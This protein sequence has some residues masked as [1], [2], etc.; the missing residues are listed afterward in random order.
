MA[1]KAILNNQTILIGSWD[2]LVLTADISFDNFKYGH[3]RI[4]DESIAKGIV[5]FNEFQQE[6]KLGRRARP[7]ESQCEAS[8]AI[9]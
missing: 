6:R 3:G 2:W 4:V 9:V 7:L 1:G 5:T 8:V